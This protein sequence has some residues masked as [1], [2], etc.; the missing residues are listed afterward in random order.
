TMG[1]VALHIIQ[2]TPGQPYFVFATFEQADNLLTASG[3]PVEDENGAVR[4]GMDSVLQAAPMDPVITSQFAQD[5]APNGY[6]TSNIQHQA[7][8]VANSTPGSRLYYVNTPNQPEPQGVISVNRRVHG[9]PQT[10]IDAN[11][12]AHA[13]MTQYAQANNLPAA[14]WQNYKLINV[15]Y[16][17]IDKQPGVAYTGADSATYYQAN[18]VVETDQNLQVF[19]GQFQPAFPGNSNTF[20]LITDW[21]GSNPTGTV[22]GCPTPPANGPFHNV[23]AGGQ[24]YNMGGC[25]GCHGNAQVKGGDFS[26]ILLGGN[27]S[28]PDPADAETAPVTGTDKFVRFF[29]STRAARAAPGAGAAGDTTGGAGGGAAGGAPAAPGGTARPPGQ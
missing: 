12:A 29:A 14:V 6:D 16:V 7:P 25:M 18:I 24:G 28:A 5:P 23:Y 10:I 19:S 17:P 2:K 3:Q 8:A 21:C 26:F 15:Q 4:A 13:A 27:N 20:P 9:I 22:D 11:E 1:L